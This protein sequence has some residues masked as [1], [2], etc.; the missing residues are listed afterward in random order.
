MQLSVLVRYGSIFTIKCNVANVNLSYDSIYTNIIYINL[1]FFY[2]DLVNCPFLPENN[3]FSV[4][5]YNIDING[6]INADIHCSFEN[7]SYTLECG[8]NIMTYNVCMY[9]ISTLNSKL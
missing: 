2:F 5:Q 1:I 9:E 4:I 8:A 3:L 6:T 7:R